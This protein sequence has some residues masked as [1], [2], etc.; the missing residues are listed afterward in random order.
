MSLTR[1]LLAAL[2]LVAAFAPMTR[3]GFNH[4]GVLTDV[5]RAGR[6]PGEVETSYGTNTAGLSRAAYESS[7][8]AQVNPFGDRW[9]KVSATSTYLQGDLRDMEARAIA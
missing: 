9:L 4:A 5:G 1:N 7:A 3:G 2:A 6:W 8:F